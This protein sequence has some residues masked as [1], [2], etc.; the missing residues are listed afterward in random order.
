MSKSGP[1]IFS[2]DY[3]STLHQIEG[4]HWWT[5][6]MDDIMDR[7]L[8]P[9]LTKRGVYHVLDMGCGSG[10]GLTWAIK[11]LEPAL[12]VGM[13]ISHFGIQ[14]CKDRGAGLV[15]GSVTDVP[16]R[17]NA[18]DL[19]ICNDVLQ[20]VE[21][22]QR[23]VNEAHRLLMPGGLFYARTNGRFVLKRKPGCLRLYDNKMLNA[24]LGEAGFEKVIVSS[25]NAIGSVIEIFKYYGI[26]KWKSKSDHDAG[27]HHGHGTDD[28][29]GG[30]MI[31]P[32][33]SKGKSLQEKF[34][35]STLRMEGHLMNHMPVLIPFGH[36]HIVLARKK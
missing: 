26:Q 19:V 17:E 7:V 28:E 29:T 13:D 23:L 4:M 2:Q 35:R 5:L 3:Y 22:D 18:F 6:G 20:H 11:R 36:T 14:H 21:D 31:R 30:L 12:M 33:K 24:L 10:V 1:K 32:S 16:L 8:L 25:A 9:R 34:M 15:V 27:H